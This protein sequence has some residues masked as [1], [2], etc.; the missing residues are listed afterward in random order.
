MKM[1]GRRR[2]SHHVCSCCNV[3]AVHTRASEK[4]EA[5]SEVA[6]EVQHPRP[7]PDETR[8]QAIV[9]YGF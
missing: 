7:N 8:M 5:R 9:R 1:R 2:Q 3:L 6:A 4:R